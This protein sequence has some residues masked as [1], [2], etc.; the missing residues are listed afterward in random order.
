MSRAVDPVTGVS[1]VGRTDDARFPDGRTVLICR[2][3]RAIRTS[4]RARP[5]EHCG[6]PMKPTIVYNAPDEA[7]A[8]RR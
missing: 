8:I 7:L 1:H 4:P 6:G 3:C 5:C 2:K